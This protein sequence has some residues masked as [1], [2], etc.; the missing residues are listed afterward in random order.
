M[1]GHRG[2]IHRFNHSTLFVYLWTLISELC[3]LI[4]VI[5]CRCWHFLFWNT[6]P[7]FYFIIWYT[8]RRGDAVVSTSASQS[9]EMSSIPVS[10]QAKDFWRSAITALSKVMHKAEFGQIWLKKSNRPQLFWGR[11]H[12]TLNKF[13]VLSSWIPIPRDQKT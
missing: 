12:K 7:V 10:N 3:D 5:Y 2:Q 4:V 8:D 9:V 1:H 13:I 11:N 6:W